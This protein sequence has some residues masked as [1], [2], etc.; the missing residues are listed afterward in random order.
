MQYLSVHYT[1][2]TIYNIYHAYLPEEKGIFLAVM[3]HI[4]MYYTQAPEHGGS[5]STSSSDNVP[6]TASK[7]TPTSN[8]G[9]EHQVPT[10]CTGR[11][12]DT[13]KLTTS[14]ADHDTMT[15][16]TTTNSKRSRTNPAITRTRTTS[17]STADTP[18]AASNPTT[19]IASN[20]QPKPT[21][22]ATDAHSEYAEARV[23]CQAELVSKLQW[24]TGELE[25]T[26]SVEYTT[27][28]CKL[29][30]AAAEALK[31]LQEHSGAA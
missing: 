3:I 26:H 23:Q 8:S 27:Q 31:S 28:L 4:N 13:F 14:P 12:S 9:S 19:E 7:K 30:T 17:N 5:G 11:T 16:C 15:T 21:A 20:S 22:A 1:Q 6:S 18:A 2:P 24:C 10:A 29:I 25:K